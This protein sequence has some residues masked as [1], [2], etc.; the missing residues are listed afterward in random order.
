MGKATVPWDIV[1]RAVYAALKNGVFGALDAAIREGRSR[2][3]DKN[4]NARLHAWGGR[5]VDI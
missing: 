5:R 3:G 2:Q 4:Q 1:A